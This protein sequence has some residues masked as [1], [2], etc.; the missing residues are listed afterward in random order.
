M[1]AAAL[2]R[3]PMGSEDVQLLASPPEEF[4]PPERPHDGMAL[5]VAQLSAVGSE[6]AAVGFGTGAFFFLVGLF[7]LIELFLALAFFADFFGAA[8]DFLEDFF[9]VFLA[10]LAGFLGAFF[11]DFFFED[12][13]F[14][15][16]L[17]D[18]F[19]TVRSF[20][21]LF[22]PPFFLLPLAIVILLLSPINIYRAFQVVYTRPSII[23]NLAGARLSPNREAQSCAPQ[24]L[25]YR[26]QS[27][28]CIQYCPQQ[29]CPA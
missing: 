15:N 7:F 22:L 25:T 4:S 3:I 19:F 14:E 13:F 18:F 16:F 6:A 9:A 23:S 24:E 21:L 20:F 8:R 26:R 17:A 10:F 11:K 28:P 12:F 1:N 29:S 2:K 27:V 5:G